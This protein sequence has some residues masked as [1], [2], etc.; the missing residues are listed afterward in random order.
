VDHTDDRAS[1]SELSRR[2]ALKAGGAAAAGAA[3]LFAVLGGGVAGAA[4]PPWKQSDYSNFAKL[5]NACWLHPTLLTQYHKTPA[6][7]LKQ[8]A[9]TL[10]PGTPAPTIP[11]KPTGS[12]GT[13]TLASKAW[14]TSSTSDFANWDVVVSA[15]SG[16]SVA[17]ST[18]CCIACPVSCFSSLSN[19]K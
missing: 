6:A 2:D 3:G 5:V 8:Y 13:S 14:R 17:V 18:L 11:K 15:A 19:S 16:T 10:P 4:T 12:F 1:S 9:I 7:V